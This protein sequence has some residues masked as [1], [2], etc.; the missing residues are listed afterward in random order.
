MDEFSVS[1]LKE[2]IPELPREK[3]LKYE[4]LGLT[5]EQIYII[6]GDTQVTKFFE[7][8]I[9]QGVSNPEIVKN[10]ANYLTSDV[11]A[12]LAGGLRIY[13]C[14]PETFKDLMTMLGEGKIT[15]RVAKDMLEDVLRGANP[16]EI[17]ETKGLLQNNSADSIRPIVQA[18]IA[19]HSAVVLEY[20]GG[21]VSVLQFLIG[22]AMKAT[23]GSAN[24][25][26][27]KTI[28]EEELG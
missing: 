25:A 19:E 4:N 18:V 24:P 13:E 1:R 7:S 12:L 14:N 15:S 8:A 9:A 22:Q 6:L 2:E 28:F 27:L 16:Q 10:I 3:R 11:A 20:R 5:R 26:L 17:A 21:K 23:K